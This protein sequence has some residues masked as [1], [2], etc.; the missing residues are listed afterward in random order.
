MS[1]KKG[2]R[3]GVIVCSTTGSG[4][5]IRGTVREC[6]KG[7]QAGG[8]GDGRREKF[9]PGRGLPNH[10]G[11]GLRRLRAG[12]PTDLFTGAGKRGRKDP[13]SQGRVCA[14]GM[15]AMGSGGANGLAAFASPF[16]YLTLH[17]K[18]GNN[19]GAGHTPC[20]I[21][22]AFVFPVSSLE[23]FCFQIKPHSSPQSSTIS[24]MGKAGW[25]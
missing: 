11:G 5:G 24:M 1:S 6:T 10:S 17:Q 16:L 20:A 13:T 22:L 3:K 7:T 8:R 25:C 19:W 2:P 14:P 12:S 4:W 21:L 18:P 15:E 9:S 23:P